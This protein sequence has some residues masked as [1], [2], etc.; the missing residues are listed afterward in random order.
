MQGKGCCVRASVAHQRQEVLV[1]N[2]MLESEH[3]KRRD[4]QPGRRESRVCRSRERVAGV[5]GRRCKQIGQGARRSSS[6][7]WRL[8]ECTRARAPP[9]Q[10]ATALPIM[11]CAALA[12]HVAM[13]TSPVCVCV[14]EGWC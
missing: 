1:G 12:C 4:G 14:C 2:H 5:R 6:V 8:P 10:M 7:N 3:C 13:P 11:S 9:H